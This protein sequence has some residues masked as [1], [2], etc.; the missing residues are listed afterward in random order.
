ML[1]PAENCLI[2]ALLS[3]AAVV[4]VRLTGAELWEVEPCGADLLA[5]WLVVTPGRFFGRFMAGLLA[6]N[7]F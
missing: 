1:L 5:G 6:E 7:K 3:L 2:S 4:M